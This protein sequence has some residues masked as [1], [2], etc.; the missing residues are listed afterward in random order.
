MLDTVYTW[1][2]NSVEGVAG[3]FL[4]PSRATH[5][6]YLIMSV[7]VV[8][9]VILW[10]SH[11]SDKERW[12]VWSDLRGLFSRDLWLHRSAVNDYLLII[13]NTFMTP[14]LRLAGLAAG[15][16]AG[17]GLY[18]VLGLA[19]DGAPLSFAAS[20]FNLVAFSIFSLLLLDFGKYFGHALLHWVPVFWEFHKP[21]HSAQVLTPLTTY[22]IHPLEHIVS[23]TVSGLCVGAAT[24]VGVFTFGAMIS[25]ISIFGFNVGV[26]L[27]YVVG[28]N[29]R[30][31]HVWIPYPQW[32]SRILI[33]PA[34]HQ[35]H[36]SSLPEHHDRNFGSIFAIWDLMFHTLYVP[37]EREKLRFGLSEGEDRDYE[38]VRNLYVVPLIKAWRLVRHTDRRKQ[39]AA[40]IEAAE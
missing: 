33:S 40:N 19:T 27:F 30:H 37:A 4:D 34:Q 5:W 6:S 31:S 9:A 11:D 13:I 14:V 36:H 1:V 25:P 26:F 3:N 22:R 10:Q 38:N 35:I 32:L 17:D 20:G 28:A 29:L 16:I 24:A 12:L 39:A 21:H 18:L 2:V 8:V 23:S 7:V 15:F